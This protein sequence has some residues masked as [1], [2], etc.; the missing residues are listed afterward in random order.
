[1][2]SSRGS[3]LPRDW[4]QVSCVSDIAGRFFTTEPSGKPL[5]FFLPSFYWQR[6]SRTLSHVS[7]Q[8]ELKGIVLISG[9]PSLSN[10]KGLSISCHF[11][12][13]KV[14]IDQLCQ[15]LCDPMAKTIH[16]ILQARIL[17]WVPFPFSSRSSQ[18][19]DQTGVSSIT[20][21]FFTD[22]AIREAPTV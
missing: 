15:T 21:R 9:N 10:S 13:M 16:G 7:L 11:N 20:G 5:N 19:R 18:P 2:P 14:K 1:M 22:W 17:E 3:S 12:C 6:P 8:P 4:T